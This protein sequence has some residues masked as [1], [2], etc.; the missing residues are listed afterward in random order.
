MADMTLHRSLPSE[1]H[2]MSPLRIV[3]AVI[4]AAL[5]LAIATVL[6]QRNHTAEAPAQSTTETRPDNSNNTPA[7]NSVTNGGNPA[8]DTTPNPTG[9]GNNTYLAQ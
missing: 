1:H 4:L 2:R 7:S 9:T 6:Y 3:I 8:D 5:L